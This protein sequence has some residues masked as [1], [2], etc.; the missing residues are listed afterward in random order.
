MSSKVPEYKQPMN[1]EGTDGFWLDEKVAGTKAKTDVS[2]KHLAA[3]RQDLDLVQWEQQFS[4]A[5]R[6]YTVNRNAIPYLNERLESYITRAA[7]VAGGAGG[8]YDQFA[9]FFRGLD[10]F[11][12][13]MLPSNSEHH[14]FTFITRPRLNLTDVQ[15]A[16]DRC[17]APLNNEDPQSVPFM[18]RALLDTQWARDHYKEATISP[19]LNY[20]SPWLTP[21]VNALTSM[22][23]W[24]DPTLY[25]ETTEGGFFQEDMTVAIG[26][27]RMSK[28]YEVNVTF[29]DIQGGPIMAIFDYWTKWMANACDG[30]MMPYA[31]AIDKNRLDY[32]V[33]IYRF[34]TDPT[35][36]FI[37]KFAKGTGCF[38]KS[39]PL[40]AVFNVN[41]GEIFSEGSATVTVPFVINH[42]S[43]NDPIIITEFNQLADRYAKGMWAN[44][45][46]PVDEER[47]Y[48]PQ[49]INNFCGLPYIITGKNR[50]ELI[51]RRLKEEAGL[52]LN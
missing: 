28:T 52:F 6:K 20:Y 26:G 34:A 44:D 3:A 29:K 25:T 38:P 4:D 43:Y 16:Q 17:F 33:S 51:F 40:G 30:V 41:Q 50:T 22:T 5:P 39:V 21:V 12:R 36:R 14:G 24:P 32:T 8:Y 48:A 46:L 18:I 9:T 2:A 35:R 27:D 42:I 19:L 23:G 47:P 1:T 15:L 13:N 31:D 11:K 49:P 37:T 45:K 10:R 7:Y